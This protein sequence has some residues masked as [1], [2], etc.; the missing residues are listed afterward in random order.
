L[1]ARK[2]EAKMIGNEMFENQ[3]RR[4]EGGKKKDRSN[5]KIKIKRVDNDK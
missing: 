3:L 1:Q 2:G 5:T 4:R